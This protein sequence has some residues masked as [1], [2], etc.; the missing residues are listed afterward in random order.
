MLNKKNITYFVDKEKRTV[1]C[2]LCDSGYLFIDFLRNNAFNFSFTA[3]L[4]NKLMMPKSFS[5][6][7]VAA[8]DDVWDEEQGKLLAYHRMRKKVTKSM[9]KRMVFW[10]KYILRKADLFEEDFNNYMKKVDNNAARRLEII[11]TFS[12]DEE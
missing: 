4:L 8:N 9:R 6:K 3:D 2:S 10:K 5:G 1:I 11:K 7:S 12:E